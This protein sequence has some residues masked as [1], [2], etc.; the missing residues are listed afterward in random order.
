MRHNGRCRNYN[1]GRA[2]APVR[3]CPTCG[4]LVNNNIS[5]E[6]CSKEKHARK[7]VRAARIVWIA[8]NNSFNRGD[9]YAALSGYDL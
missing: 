3:F 7:R 2:N 9:C 8:V 4:E 1:H 5:A 6:D